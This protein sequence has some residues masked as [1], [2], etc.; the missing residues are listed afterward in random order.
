MSITI[1]ESRPD[2]GGQALARPLVMCRRAS[3]AWATG[4]GERVQ[5]RLEVSNALLIGTGS[6]AWRGERGRESSRSADELSNRR[7]LLDYSGE[8]GPIRTYELGIASD[9]SLRWNLAGR[10]VQDRGIDP[11]QI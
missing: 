10:H 7:A 2:S 1:R 8:G 5:L 9:S 3:I 4:P 11:F 6:R